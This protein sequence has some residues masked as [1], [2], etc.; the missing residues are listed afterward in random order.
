MRRREWVAAVMVW[1]IAGIATG[2]LLFGRGERASQEIEVI[3]PLTGGVIAAREA[4]IESRL[5]KYEVI[6]AHAWLEERKD[7]KW[8]VAVSDS[9]LDAI[10]QV[11]SG[12]RGKDTPDGDNGYSI[13]PFQIGA[14]YLEDANEW[15]RTDFRL[16]EMRD[17]D[18]A[19][20]VAS[21]YLDR[22]GQLYRRRTVK[23]P[24]IEVLVRMHNGGPSGY[25]KE[26][27]RA[28]WRKVR[29]ELERQGGGYGR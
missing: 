26:S 6:P 21:G 1:Y 10:E 12:G 16:G 20:H 29:A 2:L 23:E 28:Y 9:L 8:H 14:L 17:R 27:T 5:V 11:E 3:E 19:R 4:S 15:L 18:R 24:S 22:Y 13:G 25:E 7:G